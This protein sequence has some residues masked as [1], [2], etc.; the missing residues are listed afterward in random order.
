MSTSLGSAAGGT[1]IGGI[2]GVADPGFGGVDGF[3]PATGFGPGSIII[4]L[5]GGV[6]TFSGAM[7]RRFSRRPA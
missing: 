7:M 5:I 2:G 3:L 6:L 4:A 1:S